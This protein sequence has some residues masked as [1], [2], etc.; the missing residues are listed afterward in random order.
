MPTRFESV[1]RAA[2]AV[3]TWQRRHAVAILVAVGLV[4][5]VC[6]GVVVAGSP[7]A[8]GDLATLS[9]LLI[10]WPVIRLLDRAL[11]APDWRFSAALGIGAA[12]LVAAW[13]GLDWEAARS[14]SVLTWL[15]LLALAPR[16]PAGP[17]SQRQASLQQRIAEQR[18]REERIRQEYPEEFRPVPWERA[19]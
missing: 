19:N 3:G 10:T 13:V 4:G 17:R 11:P 12:L 8:D 14:P 2:R 6:A 1:R 7:R 9:G 15:C 18:A 5:L 16:S